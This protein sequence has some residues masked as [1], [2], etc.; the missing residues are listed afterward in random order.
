[1]EW[2]FSIYIGATILGVG[3]TFFDLIGLFGGHE[4]G[5]DHDGSGDDS[6]QIE[7]DSGHEDFGNE[8][9]VHSDDEGSVVGHDRS[10][11]RNPILTLLS[12]MRNL[13]FFCLGFGPVGWFA[14]ATT[15][16]GLNSLFWSIPM[17]ALAL[18][19][20]RT[21]RRF[22]RR[23]LN[24]D[25]Q[26]SE[27][28]MERGIVTVSIGSGELGRVRIKLGDIYVERFARAVGSE[29]T[30]RVGTQVRVTDIS[31]ECVYVEPEE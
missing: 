7:A 21:V 1:M 28:L 29:A 8:D 22:M 13:I 3:I 20:T 26:A 2:L 25:I 6:G 12:V 30:I 27:L 10:E 4:G 18:V 17:G 5:S 9:I 23:E 16:S 14:L 19:G 31:D 15:G 24:S 11:K